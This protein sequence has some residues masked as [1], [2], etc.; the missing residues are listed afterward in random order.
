MVIRDARRTPVVVAVVEHGALGR[1]G[2]EGEDH[3]G[4]EG[5]DSNMRD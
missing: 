4:E 1:V 3:A 2:G 5:A